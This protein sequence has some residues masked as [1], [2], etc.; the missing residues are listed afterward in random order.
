MRAAHLFLL[1]PAL[2]ILACESGDRPLQDAA[3]GGAPDE[4][5][6]RGEIDRT[7]RRLSDLVSRAAFDSIADLYT[8]DA[9]VMPQNMP[10]VTGLDSIRAFWVSSARE[11]G[12]SSL[13]LETTD[14]EVAGDLA[15]ETGHYTLAMQPQGGAAVTDSGKYIV[16]WKRQPDGSWK[17]HRDI[18]N[19]SMPAPQG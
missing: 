8:A 2:T 1:F 10:E 17:L 9:V 4:A 13:E 18:F 11:L 6:V 3:V 5:A 16:V 14:V 12:I 15:V 7:N 19:S